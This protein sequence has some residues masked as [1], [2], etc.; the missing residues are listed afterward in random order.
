[1]PT[2]C[3]LYLYILSFHRDSLEKFSADKRPASSSSEEDSSKPPSLFQFRSPPKAA[4]RLNNRT[5]GAVTNNARKQLQQNFDGIDTEPH[6]PD[7]LKPLIDHKLSRPPENHADRPSELS[8]YNS[9]YNPSAYKPLENGNSKPEFSPIRKPDLLEPRPPD[10]PRPGSRPG[11]G[12]LRSRHGS[13]ASNHSN[14]P[15]PDS[16]GTGDDL[17]KHLRN[18]HT[19]QHK[20]SEHIPQPNGIAAVKL[21]LAD[22]PG[23]SGNEGQL[24]AHINN[25]IEKASRRKLKQGDDLSDM[26]SPRTSDKE[27]RISSA[28]I[29]GGSADSKQSERTGSSG[30]SREDLL[31]APNVSKS[32]LHHHF[33]YSSHVSV[34]KIIRMN[35]W[36]PFVLIS[37]HIPV[38]KLFH[39]TLDIDL[40]Y[41]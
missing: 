15:T 4:N 24:S 21:G 37:I 36:D 7:K 17:T 11:S 40:Y 1:M 5:N 23:S 2:T 12:R 33:P 25:K 31:M 29:R 18:N 19:D 32:Y 39:F 35:Y 6:P 27:P 34:N 8:V 14:K 9:V 22:S 38:V 13:R 3:T 20:H 41:F 26:P 30:S 16:S 10:S 28:G